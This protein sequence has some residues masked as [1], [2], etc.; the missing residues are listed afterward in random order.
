GFQLWRHSRKPAPLDSGK[1]LWLLVAVVLGAAAGARGL[2]WLETPFDPL[3]GA[4]MMPG[5]T[6]AGGLLGGWA[7]I[8]FAK[9][10]LGIRSRTGDVYVL[11]LIVGI[12]L[13]RI[14]CFL[15]GL[16]DHTY[17]TATTLV[18]GVDFG[19]GIARHPTQLYEALF[20]LGLLPLG[21]LLRRIHFA[22]PAGIAFQGFMAAYCAFRVA[23]EVIK[24]TLKLYAGLSAI[25]WACLIGLGV[26]MWQI[27]QLLTQITPGAEALAAQ[28]GAKGAA[29]LGKDFN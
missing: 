25:Q 17:G 20:V 14:G 3:T 23:V 10:R 12:A 4:W 6:I 29:M 9:S 11:P 8:E 26:A 28:S 24:P 13:G 5:K 19:D 27:R 7:A 21:L 18:W 2:A 22:W 16:D 15:A 1:Q